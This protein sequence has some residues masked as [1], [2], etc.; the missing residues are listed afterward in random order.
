MSHY[1]ELIGKC[2]AS[3]Y[4]IPWGEIN[5]TVTLT[6]APVILLIA[7]F[8]QWIIEGLVRDFLTLRKITLIKSVDFL[9][10]LYF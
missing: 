10:I 5:A 8:Q 3:V 6:T 2:W 4:K 7:F 9:S 1:F